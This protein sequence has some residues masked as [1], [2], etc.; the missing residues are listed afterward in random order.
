M[1]R[2]KQYRNPPLLEVFSEFFYQPDPEREEPY[3]L[4]LAKFWRGKLK[5]DFPRAVQPA[6]P[7]RPRDRFTSE[8]GKTLLQIGEDL[9]VVNQLP[10]YHQWERYEPVVVDCFSQYT[11]QWKPVRVN[12]AAIHSINKIDIPRLDFNL[13]EYFNLFPV[14]PDFPK[15]PATNIALSY[16]VQGAVEGDLVATSLR[17]HDSA[18]PEGVSFLLQWDYVATGG[19]QADPRQIQSWLAKAHEFLSELFG[20]TFTEA[21]LELFE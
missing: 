19:L 6:G 11:R 4:S 17:Q 7:P 20:S 8:D 18:N 10:P 2:R 14:L 3:A 21:C 1:A 15:K 13:D 12:R 9:L 16:E 5:N